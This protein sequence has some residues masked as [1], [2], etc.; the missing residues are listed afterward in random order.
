[1]YL[2]GLMPRPSC[3]L[4]HVNRDVRQCGNRRNDGTPHGGSSSLASQTP[5]MVLMFQNPP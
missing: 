3:S 2:R 1:M 5:D 4:C